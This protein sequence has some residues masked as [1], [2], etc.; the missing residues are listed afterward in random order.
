MAQNDGSPLGNI[1]SQVLSDPQKM[2]QIQQMAASLGLGAPPPSGMNP[3][4]GQNINPNMGQN[5]NPMQNGMN[6][7]MGQNMNP[8]QNSGPD[9]SGQMQIME[10]L[11]NAFSTLSQ[12][13][14]N[15]E[16]LRAMKPLLSERRARKI[17]DAIRVMQLIELLP[18]I[19][20]SGLFLR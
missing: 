13:D 11:H 19:K 4:M 9:F 7:N 12:S 10:N 6:P 20:E 2:Q 1:L 17:D 16:F 14:P 8:M 5:M 18:L 3:N 15:I